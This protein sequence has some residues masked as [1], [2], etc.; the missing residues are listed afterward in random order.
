[1]NQNNKELTFKNWLIKQ[2]NSKI[3]FY[4]NNKFLFEIN[5]IIENN[6]FLFYI[7]RYLFV[8]KYGYLQY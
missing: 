1:M 4:K 7:K 3:K 6:N 2:G 8:K 5:G